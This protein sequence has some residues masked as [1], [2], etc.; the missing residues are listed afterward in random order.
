MNKFQL[1]MTV[2]VLLSTSRALFAEEKKPL[3]QLNDYLRITGELQTSYERW[4]F[5]RPAAPTTVSANYDL[6]EVRARLGLQLTSPYVDGLVQGQYTGLY[7]LPDN[8]IAPAPIGALGLG[9]A[10]VNGNN[11]A[12][13]P[14]A[15]FLRQAYLNFKFD[16]LGLKGAALKLGRFDFADGME[17]KTADEKFDDLKATRVAQRLLGSNAIYVTRTF[18][19]FSATYNTPAFNFTANGMR[20]TQGTFDVDGQQQ[21]SKINV[22][23]AALTSKKNA[24]LPDT[25][26]RLFY[27]YFH[28]DR[29]ISTLD[30]RAVASRPLLNKQPLTLH[31]L[32]GHLLGLHT[33]TADSFDGLLWGAYQFGDWTNLQHSAWAFDA[34][35]GYQ[36]TD[37][38]LKPWLRAVYYI[39]S[40]DNNAKD[41]Q[42]TTFYAML[43]SARRYAK[44]PFYNSMNIQDAFLEFIVQPTDTT[45]LAVDVH[46]LS[47][48]NSNDLFYN[49]S[50]ASSR[51]GTNTLGF[52]GRP[53][54]GASNVGQL[55]D[56]TLMQTLGK[57][58]TG[59]F[60]YAHGFGG[61]VIKNVYG[62][63]ADADMFWVELNATF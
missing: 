44:F 14:Q 12:T 55:V 6:W 53:S 35:L 46:Q 51:S 39:S 38:P 63:K 32:G 4:D 56:M 49:G 52:N 37:V 2:M 48:A 18:D 15:V 24:L 1:A 58:F 16:D 45:K 9:G 54:G 33:R 50:G 3:G 42:H 40:G 10:Y 25:E 26:A 20:P 17:Y 62:A 7:G 19:G 60:Y 5:F 8:A 30:N 21:I 59:R 57:N 22:F 23:Y 11:G 28:D 34:E 41:G 36:R 27:T 31:T 43:P 61:S 13:S 29:P 47:L